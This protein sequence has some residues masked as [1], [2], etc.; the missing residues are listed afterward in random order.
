MELRVH[1][2]HEK[3]T[4]EI[5]AGLG[6]VIYN[7]DDDASDTTAEGKKSEQRE[8]EIADKESFPASDPPGFSG[9]S[10]GGQ[11]GPPATDA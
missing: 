1:D 4:K 2:K 7:V 3:K 8:V 10:T 9:A 5:D 6:R 11:A